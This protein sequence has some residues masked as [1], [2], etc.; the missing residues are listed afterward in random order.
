M[1]LEGLRRARGRAYRLRLRRQEA[2]E[3]TARQLLHSRPGEALQD[4]QPGGGLRRGPGSEP[5]PLEDVLDVVRGGPLP[6]QDVEV[7]LP[8]LVA[9]AEGDVQALKP[10]LAVQDELLGAVVI[11]PA[12]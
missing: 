4:R 7:Q 2:R 12:E 8:P 10:L 6:G 11:L 3:P 5:R 9:A 1:R